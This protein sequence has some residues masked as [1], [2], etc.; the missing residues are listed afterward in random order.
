MDRRYLIDINK[1]NVIFKLFSFSNVDFVS[2]CRA[3]NHYHL[4]VLTNE[5]DKDVRCESLLCLH[6]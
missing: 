2:I 1:Y 4:K 3:I 6:D 5:D